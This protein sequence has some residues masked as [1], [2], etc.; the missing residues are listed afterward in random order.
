MSSQGSSGVAAKSIADT[1]HDNEIVTK[2]LTGWGIWLRS[3]ELGLG[4]SDRSGRLDVCTY[5][6]DEMVAVDRAVA[7]QGPYHKRLLKKVYLHEDS[8]GVN[9]GDLGEAITCVE[10]YLRDHDI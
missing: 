2:L 9:P 7:S 5:S 8:Y 10:E 6:D 3:G 4:F 1:A